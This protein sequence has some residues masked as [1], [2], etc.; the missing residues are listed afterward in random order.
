MPVVYLNQDIAGKPSVSINDVAGAR[1]GTRYLLHLGHRRF[2]FVHGVHEEGFAWSATQRI[3]GFAAEM[4]AVDLGASDYQA[5]AVEGGADGD[6]IVAQLLSAR[7]LPTAVF[8][9]S[10]EIALNLLPA[11]RRVGLRIPEDLSLLGF[12]GHEMSARF[13]L[14]TVEQPVV[15]MGQQAADLA[16]ALAAGRSIEPTRI[17]VPTRLVP[18]LT[19]APPRSHPLRD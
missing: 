9:E 5:I 3:K 11:I 19:T 12:D 6:A 1:T 14:S 10:D 4:A 13:G 15:Q 17:E 18:R 2:T 8:A 16:I 7:E